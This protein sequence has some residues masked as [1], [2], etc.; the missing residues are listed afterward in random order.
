MDGAE[1]VRAVEGRRSAKGQ[2]L[3]RREG[4]QIAVGDGKHA[5]TATAVTTI[6]PAERDK[7][8]AAKA[9][10]AGTTIA[11]HDVDGGFVDEFHIASNL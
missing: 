2:D 11:G 5:A 1:W 6:R 4:V 3:R 8:F 9:R 10:T 7:F